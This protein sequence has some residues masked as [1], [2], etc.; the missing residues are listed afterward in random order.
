[1]PDPY[2]KYGGKASQSEDPYAKYNTG[3]APFTTTG[4]QI[5]VNAQASN[6]GAEI[7]GGIK[8]LGIGAVKGLGHTLNTVGSFIY[9]DAVAKHLTGV[10]TEQQKDKYFSPTTPAQQAGYTGEQIG[11]WFTPTGLEGKLTGLASKVPQFSKVAMP[12]ARIGEA[13]IEAG[14]RNKS[15][16]GDFS[17]GAKAGAI[18]GGIGETAKVAAPGIAR[19]AMGIPKRIL[20][21]G[22][23]PGEEILNSTRGINPDK[24]ADQGKNLMQGL[25]NDYSMLPGYRAP[26]VPMSGARN[27][28]DEATGIAQK[29]GSS[30]SLQKL[31]SLRT[32]LTKELDSSGSPIRV[33]TTKTT[34]A[35][36][37]LVDEFGANI[38]KPAQVAGP[39]TEKLIPDVVTPE[40]ARQLKQG[41]GE[42]VKGWQKLG[43][44]TDTID[45]AK[46][47]VYGAINGPLHAALPGSAA[48]DQRLSSL[49]P[50]VDYSERAANKEGV[51]GNIWHRVKAHTG[52]L[53]GA[54]AGAIGGYAHGGPSEALQYGLAGLAI[55]ELATSPQAGLAVARIANSPGVPIKLATGAGLQLDRKKKSQTDEQ[56]EK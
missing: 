8:N 13:T 34:E 16:G 9:P 19:I 17:T 40:R 56:D 36:T 41:V 23:T 31:E 45:A 46:Q 14:L 42:T 3:N 38:L 39:S 5:P 52:A 48:I 49:I 25:E 51:A 27:V 28:V 26:S 6:V 15:Q 20:E 32:Q 55:P 7:V 11:E 22:A 35:P 44:S 33:P 18:G 24:I 10:P 4:S 47:R 2:A 30:Q 50:L 21:R 1:M 12:A 37:G 53:T 43:T 54:T 29:R